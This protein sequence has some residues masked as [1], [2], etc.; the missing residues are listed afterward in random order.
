MTTTNKLGI[1][2][3]HAH[4]HLIENSE[5]MVSKVLTSDSTY[6][7]KE[8]TLLKSERIMHNKD[9]HEESEY[10]KEI[11]EYI[12][13]YDHVLLFG[14]TDAKVELLNILEAD[15]RFSKIKFEVMQ[16]DKM[17]EHQE[18]AFVR[19]YFKHHKHDLLP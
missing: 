10:Y 12:R 7:E 2:M 18:H 19:D 15:H 13:K 3:D 1:W 11:A 9:Q 16:A 5:P 6:E 14:P 8:K 17:S 4:A